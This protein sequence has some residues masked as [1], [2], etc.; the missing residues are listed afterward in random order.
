MWIVGAVLVLT[1]APPMTT[2][3]DGEGPLAL[4]VLATIVVA[5]EQR[6]DEYDRRAFPENVTLDSDGCTA[7]ALV[8]QRD[9]QMPAEVERPCRVVAGVWWSSYD[10]LVITEPGELDLE[11][12]VALHEAWGSG[13]WRWDTTTRARFANDL[14]DDRTLRVV[15]ASSNRSKGN[16]D[17]SQWL[18]EHEESVC[19]F[20]AD[21]IAIK[22][23]WQLT[24]DQS[25]WGRI[26]NVLRDRCPDQRVAPWPAA[27]IT[28]V[29][30]APEV[31]APASTT[32][33][34]ELRP[35]VDLDAGCDPHY[36]TVCI[37]PYPPDL[38]CGDIPHRRFEVLQPDPHTFD[39]DRNGIGCEGR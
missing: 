14:D 36:P 25:E 38:D 15:T 27:S 8:L 31:E 5:N 6:N 22:A 10:G 28:L 30:D 35:L 16:K 39:G 34:F 32:A 4:D 12:V 24:M 13:A 19:G 23:R 17:P 11:H 9:S 20:L 33:V 29:L 37:A 1:T 7:R 21:W 3:P 2:A 26:R 18:P